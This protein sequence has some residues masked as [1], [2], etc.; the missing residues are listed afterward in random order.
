ME[1]PIDDLFQA[2][3]WQEAFVLN[4]QHYLTFLFLLIPLYPS[5]HRIILDNAH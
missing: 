5:S 2:K 1:I 4:T 3:I